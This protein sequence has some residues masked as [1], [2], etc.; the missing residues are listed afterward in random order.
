MA[1]FPGFMSI[2]PVIE[3]RLPCRSH[4]LHSRR[5]CL[6][7]PSE[8][9]IAD[10]CE[11][12]I[13][14]QADCFGRDHMLHKTVIQVQTV[15]DGIRHDVSTDDLRRSGSGPVNLVRSRLFPG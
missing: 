8:F 11:V 5:Q 12:G 10:A 9:S 4:E 3:L 14:F 6:L 1:S 2:T 13:E 15:I 7:D